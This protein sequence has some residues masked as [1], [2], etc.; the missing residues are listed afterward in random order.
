MS[1]GILGYQDLAGNNLASLGIL[2][3]TNGK[4]YVIVYG[5]GFGLTKA[6]SSLTGQP[7]PSNP[8]SVLANPPAVNF[9]ASD[10]PLTVQQVI[11]SGLA[12]GQVGVDQ[13][14]VEIAGAIAPGIGSLE[15]I[16]SDGHTIRIPIN[17]GSQ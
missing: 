15:I 7:A 4:W 3:P 14:N 11:W 6:N 13:I 12:P 1:P 2:H 9:T 17:L 8:P 5:T 10:G 16:A